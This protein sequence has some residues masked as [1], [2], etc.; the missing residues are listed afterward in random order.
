MFQKHE[1]LEK[2]DSC[3]R[4]GSRGLQIRIETKR[5]L[6]PIR[7]TDQNML[8]SYARTEFG[9]IAIGFVGMGKIAQYC[10]GAGQCPMCGIRDTGN[11][12]SHSE[13][14]MK[15]II[16]DAFVAR[17]CLALW[18]GCV[19]VESGCHDDIAGF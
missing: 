17:C 2:W 8:V 12:N 18:L 13:P 16:V 4:K 9:Q 7:P 1:V 6:V 5:F 10:L 14:Q 11:N 15:S 3:V 19:V